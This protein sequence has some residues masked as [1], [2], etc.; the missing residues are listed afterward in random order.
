MND[1][2]NLVNKIVELHEHNVRH[3]DAEI[4]SL[5]ARAEQ[6]EARVAR[7]EEVIKTCP[8]Y[9]TRLPGFNIWNDMARAALAGETP[10]C[11]YCKPSN[12]AEGKCRICNG[13]TL[14]CSCP[15]GQSRAR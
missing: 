3:K 4:Q 10:A 12:T 1:R 9:G 11:V 13:E 2:E 15:K 5:R 14:P 6:A 7:L 8:V